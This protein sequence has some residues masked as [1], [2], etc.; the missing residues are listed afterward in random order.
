[1]SQRD[2]LALV[3]PCVLIGVSMAHAQVPQ[4][5]PVAVIEMSVTVGTRP[6]GQA[7]VIVGGK[8]AQTDANGRL[9]LQV[10]P[11]PIEIT[12]VKEGFNPVTVTTTAIAGQSQAI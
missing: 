4:S 6:V 7:Q 5:Q 2:L 10:A 9:T 12:I 11:G 1:M 3:L 8:T